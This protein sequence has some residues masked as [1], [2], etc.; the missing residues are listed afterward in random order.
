MFSYGI[1][2]VF[3]YVYFG[4]IKKVINGAPGEGAPLL[5]RYLWHTPRRCAI[6]IQI[7]IY[8]YSGIL[9]FSVPFPP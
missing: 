6:D 1:L 8:V 4:K 7:F 2:I 3:I 5:S 9:F